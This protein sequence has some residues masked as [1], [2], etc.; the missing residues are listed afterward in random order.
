MSVTE[1]VTK[2]KQQRKHQF[3]NGE[4]NVTVRHVNR[5]GTELCPHCGQKINNVRFGVALTPMRL[6]IVDLVSARPG[7]TTKQLGE[8]L[9][10]DGKQPRLNTVIAHV[11][12]VK[13]D[14]ADSGVTILGRPHSGYHLVKTVSHETGG[15]NV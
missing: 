15:E 2:K 12:W 3:Y 1:S 9:Y 14:L 6:R 4:P 8:A 13:D 7:I 11:R 5:Y 10:G